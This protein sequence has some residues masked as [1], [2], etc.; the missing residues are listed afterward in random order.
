MK[1]NVQ[2]D[3]SQEEKDE[4]VT[5]TVSEL[6]S[7]LALWDKLKELGVNSVSDLEVKIAR[8]K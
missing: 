6:A 4:V 5:P 3:E 2:K 7:L 8:L 1:K